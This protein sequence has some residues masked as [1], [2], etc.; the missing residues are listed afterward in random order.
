MRVRATVA[1]AR[2]AAL[3]AVAL[4]GLAPAALAAPGATTGMEDERLLFES[5]E[6]AADA[7]NAWAEL[8]VDTVRMH[9]RWTEIA[10]ANRPAGFDARDPD[11][12]AYRWEKLDTAVNLV[13]AA[14]MEILLTVSGPGH[15]WTSRDRVH[16]EGRWRPDPAAFADFARAVGRRYTGRIDSYLIWNEPNQPGWLSPQWTCTSRTRCRMTAPHLYRGL[17]RAATPALRAA[18]PG[19]KVLMGEMAPVSGNRPAQS[20]A[21]GPLPFLR[22]MACV[23][24][25]YRPDRSDACRGFKPVE[26]DG[27]GHHPHPV[28]LAPDEPS[29]RK[30]EAKLGDLDRMLKV[31]DRLTRAKRLKATGGGRLDLW[32]TEFGYQTAPPDNAIGISLSTHA[33]WIQQAAYIAWRHPRVRNLTHYQWEDESV[34]TRGDGIRAYSGWQSGLRHIDGRPKPALAVFPNPLVVDPKRRVLWGQVR[35][36]ESHSVR[37]ERIPRGGAAA[38]AFR[39][40][41]T[42]RTGVFTLKI[43]PSDGAQYRFKYSEGPYI[44]SSSP[45]ARMRAR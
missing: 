23:D 14:G 32:L 10:P 34:V 4:C 9:A 29:P 17:V 33:R 28:K 7:V 40:L 39:T 26:A 27:I 18:D 3:A 1:V 22:G 20:T 5:P 44:G 16:R 43:N 13:R 45:A 31:V 38:Q 2:L 41:Q 30:D 37:I 24:E 19:A 11:D 12:P 25:E 15:A 21:I 36:E 42:D 6:S 8:G 35:P